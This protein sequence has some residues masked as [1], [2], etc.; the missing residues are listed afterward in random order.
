VRVLHVEHPDGGG[1]GVFGDVTPMETWRP[2]ETPPPEG[3]VDVIVLYGGADNVADRERLAWM[4]DELAWLR[5]RLA[6]GV[7]VFGVCLGGQLL[8]HALGAPVR[9]CHT[10]EIGWRTVHLTAA[11]ARDPA[12]GTAPEH[13]DAFQWHSYR[14]DVPDGATLLATSDAGPQAFRHGASVG[15]QFH[16]EVDRATLERWVRDFDSD[17]DAV[18][19]GFDP[20]AALAELEQRIDGWNALGRDLFAAFMQDLRPPG[21]ATMR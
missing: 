4:R 14:F 17:P 19:Q 20:L 21:R 6:E 1:P 7:P 9:R 8:A 11:G 2:S 5:E 15:V 13:F 12:T 3:E 16:P 18:A 10:P